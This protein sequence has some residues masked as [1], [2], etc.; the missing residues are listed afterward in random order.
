MTDAAP[1]VSATAEKVDVTARLMILTSLVFLP[2]GMLAGATVSMK[3]LAPA[4]GE[5]FFLSY[6]RLRVFHTN[7]I[8]FGWLLQAGMGLIYYMVPR[9]CNNRLFSEKMGIAT[10][11]L[12]NVAVLA[13]GTGLLLGYN[14]GIEYAELGFPFDL[15]VTIA[16]VLLAVNIVLTIA[17][18][19]VKYM[20]VALWYV[21]GALVWTAVVYICGNFVT[22]FVTGV[23]QAN[24][25]FFYMHNV[26]GLI[27]TPIGLATAYYFIPKSVDSPLYS[28]T[29]SIFGF[30]I[31]A[32]VYVWTGAHHMLFGPAS[33]WLQTV[34]ILF[35]F[36]LVV[37][38]AIVVT[39]FYGTCA[40]VMRKAL[41]SVEAKF[42]LGG[43]TFYLLTCLQGPAHASRSLNQIV[44]KTDWIV[45]HA[46]MAVSGAFTFIAIAGIYHALPRMFRR[47]LFSRRLGELHF[48]VTL[49]AIIPFF[50]SLMVGGFL[51]GLSWMDPSIPWVE[52][53]DV[54]R[55]YWGIRLLSGT[56]LLLAQFIFLVNV[57]MTV[58]PA[59]QAAP[60]APR[61]GLPA[62][63]M[64]A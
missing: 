48:W 13:G 32:F 49:L 60:E 17:R 21:L 30:W 12:L 40:P 24:I 47:P 10:W 3:L 18:R 19:R 46:H 16:W 38:V 15:I 43:V 28:H 31:I 42:L 35:S 29:L 8:L 37:P 45:G 20:Y 41:A 23:N 58:W 62:R 44:S 22:R 36:S 5:V 25:A 51:Q 33:H 57:A 2:I 4:V 52:T 61:A 27:F 14:K 1:T 34:S 9:L 53:I 63:G 56:V 50:L 26:V 54:I 7:A 64:E 55:P 6:G 39:N 11:A 59:H